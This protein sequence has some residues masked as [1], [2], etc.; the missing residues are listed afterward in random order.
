MRVLCIYSN[1]QFQVPGFNRLYLKQSTAHPIMSTSPRD[2]LTKARDWAQGDL[3]DTEQHL[4]F[5]ALLKATDLVDFQKPAT[6]DNK[7]I[8]LNME[9]LLFTVGWRIAT[10]Q[11][12]NLPRFV[13]NNSNYNLRNIHN[14]L[15]A[16]DEA[17]TDWYIKNATWELREKLELRE[18]ALTKLIKSTKDTNS[19]AARLGN[20]TML[21]S[22]APDISAKEWMEVFLL[23]D[24]F[25][26]INFDGDI[27]ADLMDHM[28]QNLEGGTIYARAA[29]NHISRIQKINKE[30]FSGIIT[31]SGEAVDIFS[32]A[33]TLGDDTTEF[34]IVQTS[35]TSGVTNTSVHRRS[36]AEADM[37]R[38]LVA[39]TPA[40]APKAADFANRIDYLKAY[41]SWELAK[42]EAQKTK[43]MAKIKEEATAKMLAEAEDGAQDRELL[44][45]ESASLLQPDL[46]DIELSQLSKLSAKDI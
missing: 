36:K 26:I 18:K 25:E 8:A 31:D 46:H 10:K 6:P 32:E 40:E 11:H 23:K 33:F 3:T 27:I 37:M 13:V 22:S 35:S 19:Y 42:V 30:G 44:D 7:T 5:V 14:W 38:A 21:A 45:T 24:A 17:K 28:V 29:F 41:A 2:L 15:D 12:F 39:A 16:L 1:V 4:L 34:E 43:E 9:R 20:W